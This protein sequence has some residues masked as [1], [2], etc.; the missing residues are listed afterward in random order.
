M[1]Q[2]RKPLFRG[3][4]PG[5]RGLRIPNNTV[6]ATSHKKH[7]ERETNPYVELAMDGAGC[8]EALEV[9]GGWTKAA[10]QRYIAEKGSVSDKHTC[11]SHMRLMVAR[12]YRV[13]SKGF[14]GTN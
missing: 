13:H 11:M 9:M 6:S 4:F 7:S 5:I 10:C 1:G 3:Q 2:R 12:Q 8:V 14:K